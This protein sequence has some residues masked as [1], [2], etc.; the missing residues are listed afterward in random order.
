MSK[1]ATAAYVL[2]QQGVMTAKRIAS[3]M[4]VD[5]YVPPSLANAKG[6][7]ES[8]STFDSLRTLVRA[9]FSAYRQHIFIT[10]AGVAVR[11]IAPLLKSKSIDPAVV[12]LDHHGKHVVSLLSGHLGGANKLAAAVA[13]IVDGAA[14][15]TTATDTENLPSFDVLALEFNLVPADLKAATKVNAA[16]LAGKPVI[17][18]DPRN[19]LQLYGSAWHDLFIFIKNDAFAKLS[20]EE[21]AVMPRVTVTARATPPSETHLVLHPKT[22]HVGIGC[23]RGAKAPEILDL[24]STSLAQLELSP[25]A[26]ARVAS[27]DIKQH[28]KG[29]LEAAAALET[30]L[31]FFKA[32]ELDAVPVTNPSP[33]VQ[34]ILGIDG[35]C[36]AAALLSAGPNAVLRMPK[37][38]ERGV[39]IAVAEEG[40]S[41]V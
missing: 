33:K 37:L 17:V 15:I 36:E 13:E 14:V 9:T 1:A 12:V 11:C 27:V 8:A 20:G 7:P 22:L 35:V 6:T 19:T 25:G 10:A 31:R 41:N 26:I 40:V 28:E 2:T 21:A 4:D 39:T 29:L 24:I 16:L 30:P 32:K 23:R 38:A 18:D 34:E 5:L 3:A